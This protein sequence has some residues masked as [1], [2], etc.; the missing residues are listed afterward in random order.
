MSIFAV[1]KSKELI[2][3]Y[4][5]LVVA[6]FCMSLGIAL[7]IHAALGITPI[8]CPPYVLSLGL[9]PSVGQFTIAM[10][11]I[12]VL[13][14]VVLLRKDFP[15]IQYLQLAMAFIFGFFIDIAVWLT[16]WMVPQS[17][18]GQLV[19]VVVGA[20]VLAFG[21]SLEVIAN[22]MF[23]A[24]EG[25]T[26]ALSKVLKKPFGHLKIGFDCT[27]IAISLVFSW[28]LFGEIR[29]V[30]EGTIISALLVGFFV[31]RIQPHLGWLSRF[32]ARRS[33]VVQAIKPEYSVVTI[34]RQFGSGGHEIGEK[35]AKRLG[36]KFYDRQLI[37]LTVEKSG[38]STNYVERHE[39]QLSA[40]Q[41]IW[42]DIMMDNIVPADERL[43]ADDRLFVAQSKLVRSVAAEGP[44]VIVG[45]CGDFIL[46]DNP[47]AFH[48]FVTSTPAFA[49]ERVQKEYHYDAEKAMR[50]ITRIN[51][52]RAYHYKYYT[53][54]TWGDARHYDLFLK[55]SSFG[56]D[57]AVDTLERI[58][59]R[60]K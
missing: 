3:R 44:C 9:R 43:S 60:G 56:I 58:I 26:L 36:W 34:G 48:V 20:G 10:H 30:R 5:T 55:S 25:L 7:S 37:N 27:L 8:S 12:M 6:L 45:R 38:L 47:Q 31:G 42:R 14:Q 16:A 2:E 50:E 32:L 24:G 4:A 1:M 54:Q 22:V 17:Y 39:Q 18:V 52:L 33:V 28:I 21:I 57:G 53:R 13:L 46:K 49:C 15:K 40:A 51:K 23:I 19:L 41:S 11:V 59:K 35:L 29:G